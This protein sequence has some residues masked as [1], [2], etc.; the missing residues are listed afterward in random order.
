MLTDSNKIKEPDMTGWS[1]WHKGNYEKTQNLLKKRIRYR[2]EKKIKQLKI[3]N[4]QKTL[5]IKLKSICDYEDRN[6]IDKVDLNA[7]TISDASTLIKGLLGLQKCN[8]LAFRGVVVSNSYAF[9][10]ALDDV[11]DTIEKYQ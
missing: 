7:F 9:Q 5:I 10:C 6:P 2:L 4:E 11:Y 1:E 3:T 8:H